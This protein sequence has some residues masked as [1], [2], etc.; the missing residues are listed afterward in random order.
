MIHIAMQRLNL[1][2]NSTHVLLN[3]QNLPTTSLNKVHN[4]FAKQTFFNHEIAPTY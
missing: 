4:L 1:P 2:Q 3:N